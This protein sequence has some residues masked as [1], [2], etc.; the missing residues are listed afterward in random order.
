MTPPLEGRLSGHFT[1]CVFE[2]GREVAR[3]EGDNLLT[4]AGYAVLI[5]AMFWTCIVDQNAQMGLMLTPQYAFPI[6][7]AVGSGSTAPASSDTTLTSELARSVV[8]TG[9]YTATTFTVNFFYGTTGSWTI[10]EAGVFLN[11][12]STANTGFLFDHALVSPSVTKTSTQTCT[13]SL[14]MSWS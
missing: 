11:A 2:D 1:V 10:T 6:Y 8:Y 5:A 7:G 4:S 14:T 9:S 13:L 12:T 3:G